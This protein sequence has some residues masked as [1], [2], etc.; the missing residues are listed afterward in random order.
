MKRIIG[1]VSVLLILT[2]I[3][4]QSPNIYASK[5]SEVNTEFDDATEEL[6]DIK[7]QQAALKVEMQNMNKKIQE[8]VQQII[9][10]ETAINEKDKEI[11][12]LK[13]EIDEI[14]KRIEKR[15]EILK[16]RIQAI[17]ANG[18]KIGYLEVLLG[19]QSFNDFI[20]RANLVT[21]II[22][23][24]KNILDEQ[25]EDYESLEN[26]NKQVEKER[27]E[28]VSLQSV[29]EQKEKN[30][31]YKKEQ[32]N[33]ILDQ[34]EIEADEQEEYVMDLEEQQQLLAEQKVAI[35]KAKGMENSN[36]TVTNSK[37]SSGKSSTNVSSSGDFINPSAGVVTSEFGPRWGSMHDGIDV[38]A[39]EGTPIYAAAS[40][41]VS[42]SYYSN[43][44][45]NV[46]FITH[47]VNGKTY[48][49][50]YAH[51]SSRAVSTGQ[52]VQQGQYIGG[53]GNTGNS[54]GTHLHFEIHEGEWNISKSN[55]VDPRRYINF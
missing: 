11:A 25:M 51:L 43:S 22:Q 36:D 52:V 49:T 4:F 3:F 6:E 23:A 45:G 14:Q 18:G 5:L 13:V 33:K 35:E 34:L 46:I 16:K 38:A 44:Y 39:G 41:V 20:S 2:V 24:D 10:N 27:Q 47:S 17:Q 31:E 40:G 12:Q 9:D 37:E 32:K 8:T 28:L 50:V 48:Q 26:K 53:M 55:A 54:S 21:T 19:S 30:L 15:D 7:N 29:L 1:I 42:R